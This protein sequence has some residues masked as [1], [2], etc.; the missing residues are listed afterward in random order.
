MRV[1]QRKLAAA[2]YELVAVLDRASLPPSRALQ[3]GL[4][5]VVES[6]DGHISHWAL[7][8]PRPT[9]DFHDPAGW[10]LRLPADW[11]ERLKIHAPLMHWN[12]ARII[13]EGM[14][15][16]VDYALTDKWYLNVDVKQIFLS[17]DA[18]VN[19]GAVRAKTNHYLTG[20]D[21]GREID[22]RARAP[23]LVDTFLTGLRNAP[24]PTAY[25]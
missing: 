25:A 6:M 15:L 24:D 22:L 21:G 7:H 19:G 13:Q 18:K 12:K 2:G 20:R 10:T 3:I 16:G 23:W 5:A 1:Q 17:T 9:P 11:R 8:H 4:C 14:V